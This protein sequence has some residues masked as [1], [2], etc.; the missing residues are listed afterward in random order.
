[1]KLI[2]EVEIRNSQL[3]VEQLLLEKQLVLYENDSR[4]KCALTNLVIKPFIVGVFA[5]YFLGR[6]E[7]LLH[8]LARQVFPSLRFWSIF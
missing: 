7:F 2:D 5:H 8:R 3:D 4:F 1:M 6:R